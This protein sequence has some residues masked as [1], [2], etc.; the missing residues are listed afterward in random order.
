MSAAC[1]K[2]SASCVKIGHGALPLLVRNAIGEQSHERAADHVEQ[3]KAKP[4][5]KQ[6][7]EPRLD[8]IGAG[9]GAERIDYATEQHRFGE[10]RGGKGY[11][12]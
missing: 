9:P 7:R 3:T 5:S 2:P 12:T 4:K 6:Q 10:R 1:S 8:H 11:I